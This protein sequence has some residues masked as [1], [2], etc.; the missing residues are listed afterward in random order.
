MALGKLVHHP[1]SPLSR[2]TLWALLA[3]FIVMVVGTVGVKE[4]TNWRWIDAFYFMAMVATAQGPPNA[5]TQDYAKIFVAIMAFISIG[6]LVTATG[7]I[8]GPYLGY[9]FHKGVHFAD[10]ELEKIEERKKQ[11][12]QEKKS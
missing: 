12:N 7:I 1:L 3:I 8:F 4:L 2:R 5:P 11:T 6:T 10:K 9:L